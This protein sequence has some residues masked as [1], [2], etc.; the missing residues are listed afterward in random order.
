[1]I[2]PECG[3]PAEQLHCCD[4]CY[5]RC[6][7][8]CVLTMTVDCEH[9]TDVWIVCDKVTTS[10]SGKPL[11]PPRLVLRNTHI[12]P[13][14]HLW[15]FDESAVHALCPQPNIVPSS[16]TSVNSFSQT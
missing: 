7:Y 10:I 8:D 1:M 12:A 11:N 9:P 4:G 16:S 2:C 15:R 3:A 6:C 13:Y 5:A 14:G